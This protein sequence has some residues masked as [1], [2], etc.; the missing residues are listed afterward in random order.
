MP[1][2]TEGLYQ[3]YTIID[4]RT[5]AVIG[6]R[7]FTLNLDTDPDAAVAL[8]AYAEAIRDKNPALYSDLLDWLDSMPVIL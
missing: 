7:T 5:G 3:K 4:N 6:D 2:T 8:N 1:S